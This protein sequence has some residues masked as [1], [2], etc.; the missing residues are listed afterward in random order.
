MSKSSKEAKRKKEKRK[1]RLQRYQ[2]TLKPKTEVTPEAKSKGMRQIYLIIA[3]MIGASLFM[4]YQ[5][6]NA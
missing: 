2:N 5:L 3:L 4:F 6:S 1:K